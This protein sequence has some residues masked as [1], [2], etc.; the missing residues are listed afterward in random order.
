MSDCMPYNKCKS[1]C[2]SMGASKYRWFH[3]GCCECVG[4]NCVGHGFDTSQCLQCPIKI[5]SE[6]DMVIDTPVSKPPSSKSDASEDYEVAPAPT[7]EEEEEKQE[8]NVKKEDS[9][10]KIEKNIP[11]SSTTI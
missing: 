3:D 6:E 5:V 10:T 2:A 8:N 4:P 1:S 11:E 9:K 7:S